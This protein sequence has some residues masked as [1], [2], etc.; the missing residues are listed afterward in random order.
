VAH[1]RYLHIRF[2][3]LIFYKNKD[4]SISIVTKLWAG[5]LGSSGFD[6][7]WG[8]G[9]LL[10]ATTFGPV[11][12]PTQSPIQWVLGV[13]QLRC[14]ADHSPPS[15]TEDKNIWSYTSTPP[16]AFMAWCLLKHRDN[17]IFIFTHFLQG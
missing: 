3:P 7:Q 10:F 8:I 14:E 16:Y 6:S 9:I 12:G 5:L 15:S 13:K 17:F 2:F 11:Q 4:S 1:T